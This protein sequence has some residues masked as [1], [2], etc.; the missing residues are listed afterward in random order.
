MSLSALAFDH[1][2]SFSEGS[3]CFAAWKWKNPPLPTHSTSLWC[4]YITVCF[5]VA[6]P[7]Y[8]MMKF[9]LSSLTYFHPLTS[10]LNPAANTPRS[11]NILVLHSPT[12]HSLSPPDWSTTRLPWVNQWHGAIKISSLTQSRA[13]WEAKRVN[14][15]KTMCLLNHT[16]IEMKK[17]PGPWMSVNK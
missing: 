8:S 16:Y 5:Q 12:C 15:K 6:T 9:Q 11:P 2:T 17:E 13:K 10:D 4:I 14:V 1:Q 7:Q 3:S